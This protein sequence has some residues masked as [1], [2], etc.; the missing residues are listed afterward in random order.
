M[1]KSGAVKKAEKIER[2]L[3]DLATEGEGTAGLDPCYEGYFAC[4]NSQRYYEAHD[5]LEHL[6]LQNRDENYA[7]YKGLIQLAGAYVHLQ[8]Q[9]L[10]PHHPKDRNRAHPAARLFHLAA[11]NLEAYRPAHL[12]LDVE[13]VWKLSTA[14]ADEIVHTGY[15]NPWSPGEAPILSLEGAE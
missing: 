5:V 11:R 14:M 4:F 8:K 12:H 13:R 10:R 3:G 9:F 2:M 1:A 7:F 6:W 15:K